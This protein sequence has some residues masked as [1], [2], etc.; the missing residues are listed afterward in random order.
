MTVPT[1]IRGAVRSVTRNSDSHAAGLSVQWLGDPSSAPRKEWVIRGVLG[2]G[3]VMVIHA[4]TKVGKTQ[5]ATH[6]SFAVATGGE[7]FGR[8]VARAAVLYGALRRLL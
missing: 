5:L 3:E 7:I 6:I 2:A 8:P 4:D 1:Q